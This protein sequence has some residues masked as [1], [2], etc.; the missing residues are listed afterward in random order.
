M[1]YE[2]ATRRL[3]SAIL[4]T[5]IFNLGSSRMMMIAEETK[6]SG[7][8]EEVYLRGYITGISGA[9]CWSLDWFIEKLFTDPDSEPR[10]KGADGKDINSLRALAGAVLRSH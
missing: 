5:G 1:T 4:E 3:V 8:Y 9:E 10:L 2:H 6:G 7:D